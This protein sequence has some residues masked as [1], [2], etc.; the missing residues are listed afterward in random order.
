MTQKT[1]QIIRWIKIGVLIGTPILLLL[2][3]KTYF[4]TGQSISIFELIGVD[5]YYSKGITKACMHLIHFDI[6]GAAKY[7]KLSF[8]VLPLIAIVWITATIREIRLLKSK[9]KNNA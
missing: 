6:E 5:G 9:I 8:I 4:D 2:L 7:N 3:P 1:R